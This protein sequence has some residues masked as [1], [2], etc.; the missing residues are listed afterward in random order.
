MSH[1]KQSFADSF[2]LKFHAQERQPSCGGRPD[3]S[4]PPAT[5]SYPPPP[6]T[7]G[8]RYAGSPRPMIQ[9]T[10]PAVHRRRRRLPSARRNPSGS[11][12]MRPPQAHP[13]GRW[14]SPQRSA[15]TSSTCVCLCAPRRVSACELVG[16]HRQLLLLPD[17]RTGLPRILRPPCQLAGAGRG[18]FAASGLYSSVSGG[19]FNG[20]SGNF[21][22]VSA[23]SGNRASGDSSSVSGGAQSG[24]TGEGSSVIGATSSL[25]SGGE[26]SVTGGYINTASGR[27]S[28]VSGGGENVASGDYSSVSGGGSIDRGVAGNAAAAYGPR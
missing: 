8:P 22:S 16:H 26:S 4:K 19:E 18:A 12:K 24:A 9:E 13:E 10:Q 27:N 21:S 23:G 5:P 20:G 25:A 7:R 3:P 17:S 1:G 2:P 28:S 15:C 6:V 11:D 14:H